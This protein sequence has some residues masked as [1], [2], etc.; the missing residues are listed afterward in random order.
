MN[1]RTIDDLEL[2]AELDA[3]L[4]AQ[5][6]A[7]L[8]EELADELYD[9]AGLE[10]ERLI[11]KARTCELMDELAI[12]GNV[13]DAMLGEPERA[14]AVLEHA[15]ASSGIRN[16]AAFAIVNFR[17]GFD[18]R[19]RVV[20]AARAELVEEAPTLAALE[21]AWQLE[22]EGSIVAPYVLRLMRSAIERTGGAR[23]L[24]EDAFGS[25]DEPRT[26]EQLELD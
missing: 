5:L 21:L 4:R 11:A 8:V 14:R 19:A 2:E 26:T 23:R 13:R 6:D 10:G 9:V 15:I 18:P 12:A 3:E 22:D 25:H 24:L 7:E 1:E 17:K 20:V 16:P